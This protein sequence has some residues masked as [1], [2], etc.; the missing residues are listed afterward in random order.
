MKTCWAKVS[1][2]VRSVCQRF[3]SVGCNHSLLLNLQ[4]IKMPLLRKAR[5][6]VNFFPEFNGG[7]TYVEC[8]DENRK[9]YN[10]AIFISVLSNP[11]SDAARTTKISHKTVP[12]HAIMR[13]EL[14]KP[15]RCQTKLP[16]NSVFD[17][18][19]NSVSL[20]P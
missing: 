20:E 12:K 19:T 8:F 18:C 7:K 6:S 3:I 1:R 17:E 10:S 9:V 15:L 13:R 16:L 14:K 11:I 5:H 4:P 2:I